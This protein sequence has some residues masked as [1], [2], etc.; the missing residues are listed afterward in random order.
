MIIY[1]LNIKN[2]KKY[3]CTIENYQKRKES[4]LKF[5]K[6]VR[7]KIKINEERKLK[8][9]EYSKHKFVK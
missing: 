2:D 3:N 4:L 7:K 5:K 8:S 6:E 1:E 9:L